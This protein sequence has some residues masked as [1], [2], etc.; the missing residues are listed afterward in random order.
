MLAGIENKPK[1]VHMGVKFKPS[2]TIIDVYDEPSRAFLKYTFKG[3][4]KSKS[5]F[6][7][8]CALRNEYQF[9]IRLSIEDNFVLNKEEKTVIYYKFEDETQP[10][11]SVQDKTK[12]HTYQSTREESKHETD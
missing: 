7:Y 3:Y 8:P 9:Q 1:K 6:T 2:Q 10:L 11:S 5:A 12:K 4:M